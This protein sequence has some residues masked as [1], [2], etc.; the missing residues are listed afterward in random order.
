M[1]GRS[2]ALFNRF[3]AAQRREAP[4]M[5]GGVQIESPLKVLLRTIRHLGEAYGDATEMRS[6]AR[7]KWPRLGE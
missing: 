3:W 1:D 6:Q 4:F 5:S 2:I 7:K